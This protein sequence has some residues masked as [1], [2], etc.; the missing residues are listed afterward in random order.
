MRKILSLVTVASTA[1]AL[2]MP[3]YANGAGS[4]VDAAPRDVPPPVEAMPPAEP[5]PVAKK[6][7]NTW[8]WIVGAIGVGAIIWAIADDDEDEEDN[9]SSLPL[10]LFR[11]ASAL[12]S[13][14]TTPYP[15]THPPSIPACCSLAAPACLY[16]PARPSSPP[17]RQTPD[18]FST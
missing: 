3:A 14:C 9:I 10:I 5:A 13:V 15:L 1:L 4:P 12:N 7:D 16:L 17:H 2:S 11:T 8:L 18:S 6:S